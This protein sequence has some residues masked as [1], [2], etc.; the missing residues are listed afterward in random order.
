MQYLSKSREES[1]KGECMAKG[2]SFVL[3]GHAVNAH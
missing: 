3:Q 1:L 2:D